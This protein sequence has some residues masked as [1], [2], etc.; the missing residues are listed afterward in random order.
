[1]KGTPNEKLNP[2]RDWL[3]SQGAEIVKRSNEWEL[4]R[5][6]YGG[7]TGI[8]YTS[9]KMQGDVSAASEVMGKAWKQYKRGQPLSINVRKRKRRGNGHFVEPLIKRDGDECWYCGGDFPDEDEAKADPDRARTVEHLVPI[10]CG[11]PNHIANMV[12]AHF[13]C[14]DRAGHKSVAEKV[15]Y[16][17]QLRKEGIKR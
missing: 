11:G 4:L 2:F 7:L 5:F 9:L 10:T 17:E 3:V 12:L 6:R 13:L 15:R 8:A 14:N 16:R 1:M